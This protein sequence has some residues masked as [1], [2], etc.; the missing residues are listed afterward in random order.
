M[1]TDEARRAEFQSTSP[2]WGMTLGRVAPDKTFVIS[3]HIPRVG[4]DAMG[5][6]MFS[7]RCG[8]SIH[9]PRV[10]DDALRR[11]LAAGVFSISIHIPRVG[12]DMSNDTT[13]K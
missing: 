13:E 4:D 8:I 1:A 9:I 11:I 3:I 5:N 12:D 2:V 7:A 10:G 6:T